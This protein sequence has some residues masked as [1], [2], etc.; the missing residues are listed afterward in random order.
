MDFLEDIGI[1]AALVLGGLFAVVVGLLYV[2]GR[3]E[4]AGDIS[5]IEQVRSDIEGTCVGENED[6]IGQA[7][8]LNRCIASQKTYNQI[9]WSDF[10]VPD[11]WNDVK[12][13]R[14]PKKPCACWPS[15]R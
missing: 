15:E 5:E 11:G 8:K 10:L 13:I 2:V 14:I 9:W 1:P 6:V 12:P 4:F 7:V 3:A